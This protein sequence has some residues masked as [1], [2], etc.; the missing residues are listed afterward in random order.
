MSKYQ[1]DLVKTHFQF[2]IESDWFTVSAEEV[3]VEREYQE[4]S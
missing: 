2:S 1:L 3:E 4:N